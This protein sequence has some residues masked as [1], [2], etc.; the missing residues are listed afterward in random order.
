MLDAEQQR[1]IRLAQSHYVQ[2]W[3]AAV[4]NQYHTSELGKVVFP[5]FHEGRFFPQTYASNISPTP[6]EVTHHFERINA[7]NTEFGDG[8]TIML[9]PTQYHVFTDGTSIIVVQ[10]SSITDPIYHL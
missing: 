10:G 5:R 9:I 7:V 8:H 3:G 1:I 6:A 2:D 4:L